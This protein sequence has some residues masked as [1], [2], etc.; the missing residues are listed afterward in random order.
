MRRLI[1]FAARSLKRESPKLRFERS[2]ASPAPATARGTNPSL[3]EGLIVEHRATSNPARGAAPDRSQGDLQ[4]QHVS[5][6]LEGTVSAAT[7]P[8]PH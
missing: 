8:R 4:L 7:Q 6:V 3:F 1:A 5:R 2:S